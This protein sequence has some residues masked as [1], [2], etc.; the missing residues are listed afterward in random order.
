MNVYFTVHKR[1]TLLVKKENTVQWLIII[2]LSLSLTC[3]VEYF[4]VYLSTRSGSWIFNRVANNGN[5]GDMTNFRRF[6]MD[7]LRR[8][9]SLAATLVK[10]RLNKRFDH[11]RYGLQP[12]FG[13]LSAHP[14]ANDELP[15][16]II[17][18]GVIIKDD[19]KEF[20]ETGVEFIDGSKVDN[21]DAVVLATGYLFG[22]P[23]IDESVLTVK[24]NRVNLYK[25][26]F[27]PDLEKRTL[28]IIGC[29]QPL[30]AIMPV[31]EMQCRLATRVFKVCLILSNSDTCFQSIFNIVD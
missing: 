11:K 5:P 24:D 16:R 15:N 10:N 3:D 13:P 23:F 27:P 12:K 4:Q 22:F 26:M 14:T 2:F 19:V 7:V 28:A 21:I 29:F 1:F 31:C 8:M 6:R 18:G 17:A 20:T 9:P 25:N 30:G